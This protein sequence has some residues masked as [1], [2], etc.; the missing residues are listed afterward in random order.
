MNAKK[1]LLLAIS[2]S[3]TAAN[4]IAQELNPIKADRYLYFKT[5]DKGIQHD[6]VKWGLDTAWDSEANVRRGIA[7]MGKENV[8]VVRVSFQPTYALNDDNTLTRNQI[9]AVN[10]RIRHA[11]LAGTPELMIN[12]DHASVDPYF[13][14]N[15]KANADHWANLILAT[16]RLYEN[17]GLKVVSVAPFNEPDY[18]QTGQGSLTDFKE[19][20]KLLKTTYADEME[21]VR[22]SGGNTLNSDQASKYYNTLKPYIDEGCSHQLA[23][24]FDTY[25]NFFK[26]V[27]QDGLHST[28][29]EMHNVGDAL[30]ALEYGLQTGIWWGFD[31]RA[32]G[33]M[34]RATHGDRLAYAENRDKWNVAAVYRNNQDNLIE[35][36]VGGSERQAGTSSYAFVCSDRLVY[37]DGYGPTHEFF[38]EYP[39]GTG[40]QVGQTN[41]ER[42]IDISYGEDVQP[43]VI[44]GTYM[45]MNRANKLVMT[46]AA[47]TSGSKLQVKAKT[48]AELYQWKVEPVS[49]RVGG[50]FS[51]YSIRLAAND[52]PIDVWNWSLDSGG[53][54]NLFDGEMGDNEQYFLQYAGDGFYYIRSRY[55]NLYLSAT[56]VSSGSSIG[57]ASLGNTEAKRK[58][59]QW[60]IVSPDAKCELV[61]PSVP[62]NLQAEG[63]TASFKL[64]WDA[65]TEEDI[66][67]Y[68][69]L[70]ADAIDGGTLE[71]D[72]IG[73]KIKDCS[74]IDRNCVPGRGYL[75][76]IRAIDKTE[77]MSDCSDLI[78][79]A[80]LDQKTMIARWEFDETTDDETENHLDAA[81]Y[82]TPSYS[83]IESMIKSGTNSLTLNGTSNFVQLPYCVASMDEMTICMWTRWQGSSSGTWQRLF[84][85]GNS[86]DEYMFLTPLASS[87]KMRFAIKNRAEEQHLDA[88]VSLAS[89]GWKH[90]ALTISKDA[91]RIYINGKLEA[92]STDI[93]IRPS[94]FNPVMNYIGKSQFV[95]DPLY[96]GYIDD[97]RIYN[98]ALSETEV[99]EI[100][101]GLENAI[102]D[103]E[104]DRTSQS[105]DVYDMQ[106][107]KV[108]NM[109][110]GLYI[111]GGKKVLI[112]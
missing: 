1:S 82:G 38:M 60:R 45:L 39:G 58:L 19:I 32:R 46:A 18:T 49:S 63:N 78:Y 22:I 87:K 99:S 94:H 88:S 10:S 79:A 107:R 77:N 30:V 43:A 9:N 95:G 71:W 61:A 112:K 13:T 41:A 3:V 56:A 101:E 72:V 17:A 4:C 35:C 106:G 53:Q 15:G 73:R 25:A 55:S 27:T 76:R 21:G 7:F 86:E 81:V 57:Q 67:G 80:P 23:G 100:A 8:E 24:G 5:T 110:K 89:V 75:Y 90:V 85:F 111:I 83:K 65:N 96:K 29:D 52:F 68:M 102:D 104:M 50:D 12:D 64:T 36:F 37:Y 93:T 66:D 51:Y 6:R 98:Y 103:V 16:K 59:Q 31:A 84:D 11:K 62:V 33:Q 69:I 97:V 105:D 92:E 54:I 20:C 2:I 109:S 108:T 40:Y 44:N 28:A 47:T 48:K 26:E 42:V 70:R 34:C 91:I 14:S 74:F